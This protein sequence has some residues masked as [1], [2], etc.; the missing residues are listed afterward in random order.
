MFSQN[1]CSI[2]GL[3]YERQYGFN[4]IGLMNPTAFTEYSSFLTQKSS[5]FENFNKTE[6]NIISAKAAKVL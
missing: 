1:I 5:F 2:L 6:N 3:D 4:Y